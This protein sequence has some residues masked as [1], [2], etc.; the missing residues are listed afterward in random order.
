MKR[1]L[2]QDRSGNE[3]YCTNLLILLVKNVLCGNIHCHEG[4]HSILFS[5]NI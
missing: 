3:D 2:D 1:D 4:F 5:Y